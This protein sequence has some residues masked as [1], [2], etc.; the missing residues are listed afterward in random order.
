MKKLLSVLLAAGLFL[1]LL[2]PSALAYDGEHP[3]ESA[4]D[5]T[6]EDFASD[7]FL[8]PTDTVVAPY[9]GLVTDSIRDRGV[10]W[11]EGTTVIGMEGPYAGGNKH[12]D[13]SVTSLELPETTIIVGHGAFSGRKTVTE[14]NFGELT[15]LKYIGKSAFKQTLITNVD[16]SNTQLIRLEENAFESCIYIKSFTAPSTLRY[17]GK[18]AFFSPRLSSITLNEGLEYIG[19]G[20]FNYVG[21]SYN[22]VIIPSTV[23]YIGQA[24]LRLGATY[25]VYPGTYGEQWCKDNNVRYTYVQGTQGDPQETQ[26]PQATPSPTPQPPEMAHTKVLG[27]VTFS[28]YIS[29][30]EIDTLDAFHNPVHVWWVKV[31]PG[32]CMRSDVDHTQFKCYWAGGWGAGD[33]HPL[34]ETYAVLTDECS[35][36]AGAVIYLSS[37][38][39]TPY[40]TE[41]YKDKT[42][43]AG[44][45][46]E[47]G[48]DATTVDNSH[49]ITVE[50]GGET[51]Y[52]MVTVVPN[53]AYAD[54][55]F[56]APKPAKPIVTAQPNRSRVIV[57]GRE[58]AFDA[59]TIDENN[60]FKL[61]DVAQALNGTEKQFNVE[62]D[63]NIGGYI[64]G[65]GRGV[66]GSIVTYTGQPYASV[67]GELAAGDGTA[68]E[69]RLGAS[70]MYQDGNVIT[71][72]GYVIGENNY[73]KLR[74]LGLVYHF[75]VRWDAASNAV[76]IDTGREYDPNT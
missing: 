2:T 20:A 76:V 7:W 9:A 60:Y 58:V 8:S 44:L 38:S 16:L 29:H 26:A 71:P 63:P 25:Q 30:Q 37:M 75:D 56:A 18:W 5:F 12:P 57:D 45:T 74:D 36:T 32:A 69:G 3:I 40:A 21:M 41:K 10:A 11:P 52:Y 54:S 72:T 23:T 42:W 4:A 17:I 48:Y 28:N 39:I 27:G 47:F 67:G 51:Y 19:E 43:G 55:G 24:G 61:R 14:V 34:G 33:D 64:D 46:W 70:P 66:Q 68:R 13:E 62:W 73:F 50:Q 15:H 6:D 65:Q 1:G 49:D 53:A 31:G 59:Y 35:I 22:N